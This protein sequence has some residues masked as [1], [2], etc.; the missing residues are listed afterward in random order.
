MALDPD[1]ARAPPGC[2]L[3]M[4]MIILH[5]DDGSD[6]AWFRKAVEQM[7]WL[8][9]SVTVT[10][11]KCFR[12]QQS[13]AT[14]RVL[15]FTDELSTRWMTCSKYYSGLV[16]VINLWRMYPLDRK[17]PVCF[18]GRWGA[19]STSEKFVRSVGRDAMVA[20]HEKG[21]RPETKA[22]KSK[23]AKKKEPASSTARPDDENQIDAQKEFVV[24]KRGRWDSNNIW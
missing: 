5:G 1:R 2:K 20:R 24:K 11:T 12:H 7:Y 19:V 22:M 16:K 15:A 10:T 17:P 8:I 13:L 6:E 9:Q 18:A 4:R 14:G 3:F 23:K 21:L